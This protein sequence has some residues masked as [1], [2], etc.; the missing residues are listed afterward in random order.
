MRLKESMEIEGWYGFFTEDE[1][2][3]PEE[4][5]SVKTLKQAENIIDTLKQDFEN[6]KP[7]PKEGSKSNN[8]YT[9]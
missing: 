7:N 8:N 6:L 2:G 3:C 1:D 5:I 4:H 9:Q